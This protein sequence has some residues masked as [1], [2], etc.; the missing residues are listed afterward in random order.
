MRT[1]TCIFV[2]RSTRCIHIL[3]QA[4][5]CM[6]QPLLENNMVYEVISY[7]AVSWVKER[8]EIIHAFFVFSLDL[9]K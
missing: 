8:C 7:K 3:S 9:A 5:V 6:A 1:A 4:E 2:C